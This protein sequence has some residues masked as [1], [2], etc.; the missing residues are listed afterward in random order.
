MGNEQTISVAGLG[1]KKLKNCER[2]LHRRLHSLRGSRLG[3]VYVPL[4]LEDPLEGPTEVAVPAICPYELFA[5]LWKADRCN[6]SVFN[7]AMYGT[8]APD[9]VEQIWEA[10]DR[11]SQTN[12]VNEDLELRAIRRRIFPTV[13]HEDGG[14]MFKG[15]SFLIYTWSSKLAHCIDI[16]DSKF[17]AIMIP[18]DEYV[19]GVTDVE[20]HQ[21]QDWNIEVMLSGVHPTHDHLKNPMTGWRARL[22]GEPLAGG[23]RGAFTSWLGDGKEEA[24]THRLPRKW[25]MNFLCKKCLGCRHMTYGNAYNFLPEAEWKNMIVTH[26]SYLL[27]C[28]RNPGMRS[29]WTS[30]KSWEYRRNRDDLLHQCWLGWGKDVGGQLLKEAGEWEVDRAADA[31]DS[32]DINDGLHRVWVQFCKHNLELGKPCGHSPFTT[33]TISQDSKSDICT[34]ETKMKAAKAKQVTVFVCNWAVDIVAKGKDVSEHA[35][36]RATMAW[37]LLKFLQVTD[38]GGIILSEEE[39]ATAQRAGFNVN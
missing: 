27:G 25:N 18:E 30:T 37:N 22:A 29:P 21:W 11:S 6:R 1:G 10:L 13:W 3:V 8:E 33:K 20:I 26:R 23:F 31:G 14:E 28:Q 39:A 9:T 16:G 7:L 12:I 2:D 4:T 19:E 17:F 34:L 38:E 5:E 35:C 15:Q 36:R 24:R 32:I